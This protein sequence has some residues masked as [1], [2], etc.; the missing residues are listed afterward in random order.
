ML[1]IYVNDTNGNLAYSRYTAWRAVGTRPKFIDLARN[2]GATDIVSYKEGNIVEQV[3]EATKG[4]A[5]D[6]VIIA[7]GGLEVLG[8]GVNMVKPW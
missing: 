6:R 4:Q 7:R 2:Y 3:L 1:S 5:V 8:Q